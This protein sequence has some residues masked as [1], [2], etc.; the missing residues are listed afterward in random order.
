[1]TTWG[2]DGTPCN[3]W[4]RILWNKCYKHE[5]RLFLRLFNLWK[6]NKC[7]FNQ[8]RKEVKIIIRGVGSLILLSFHVQG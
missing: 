2:N 4:I 7:W 6:S 1:M 8:V 3:L 5:Y